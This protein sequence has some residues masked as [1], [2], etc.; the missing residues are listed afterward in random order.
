MRVFKKWLIRVNFDDGSYS[1]GI[2]KKD[3]RENGIIHI[4][5]LYM[6]FNFLSAELHNY[7]SNQR[8]SELMKPKKVLGFHIKT[9]LKEFFFKNIAFII[10]QLK[11]GEI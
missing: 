7:N 2:S 1:E 3:I 11:S 6:K 5:K 4:I 9:S 8:M 10:N